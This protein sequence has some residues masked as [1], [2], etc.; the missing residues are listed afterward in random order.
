MMIRRRSAGFT[1]IELMITLVVAAILV[2]IAYPA[3]Q[4][5]VRKT[6]RAE[7]QA[8]LVEFANAMERY[9]TQNDT[10][11]GAPASLGGDT[12][13]YNLG[14]QSAAAAAFTLRATPTGSQIGDGLLEINAAGQKFWD[15][16]DDGD[17]A[18]SGENSW[19]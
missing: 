12:D 1:L 2:S 11:A 14:I 17:T 15:K 9:Y 6:R 18:D 13:F 5:H 10:Y 16:N 8:A 19:D 7:A 4:S 3:Y